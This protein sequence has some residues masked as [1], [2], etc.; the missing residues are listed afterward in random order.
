MENNIFGIMR[1]I[2]RRLG[3]ELFAG[4][5]PGILCHLGKT[6]STHREY[7]RVRVNFLFAHVGFWPNE[8]LIQPEN[9]PYFCEFCICFLRR[10]PNILWVMCATADSVEQS[11]W[12]YDGSAK[13]AGLLLESTA[14]LFEMAQLAEPRV[15]VYTSAESPK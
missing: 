12:L 14:R 1:I 7:S 13:C 2:C 4:I 3:A 11:N 9:V 10:S 8:F 15:R 5:G 6:C